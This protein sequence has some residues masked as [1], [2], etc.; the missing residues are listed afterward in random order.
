MLL[1]LAIGDAYGA[2]VEFQDRNWIRNN[3]DFTRFVNHRSSIAVP[4]N[5]L[6]AFTKNYTPWDYTDDTEMTI[7]VINAIISGKEF[8][9]S[10][11]IDKWKEEYDCGIALKGYGRNGHGSMAWFYNGKQTIEQIREFQKNR[12]NPGNAP[13][14]RSI[15]LGLV[16]ENLINKYAA[17]NANATHPHVHAII[18][19]Q[20]IARA[21]FFLLVKKGDASDLIRYCLEN[22]DFDQTFYNYLTAIDTLP[23][24]DDLSDHDFEILCGRQPIEPPYFLAGINGM[25]SDSMYTAGCGLYVLKNSKGTM[26]GLKKAIYLGGDV[27]SI[28]SIVTAI[29]SGLYGIHSLPTY[30]IENVEGY[31]YLSKIANDFEVYCKF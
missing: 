4:E 11:L 1:G 10:L 25:P 12:P 18:S 28:A 9:E 14:M 24:Y 6:E 23:F 17:I 19:S 30:M 27:D 7:G 15:P 20:C 8:S 2:G 22:V 5:K 21:T 13:A 31:D 3:I 26:D 16:S 29:L